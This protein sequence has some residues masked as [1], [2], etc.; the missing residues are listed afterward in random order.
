MISR[1]AW[2][3]ASVPAVCLLLAGCGGVVLEPSGGGRTPA[4]TGRQPTTKAERADPRD[5]TRISQLMVPLLRAANSPRPLD[6]VRV[7]II[8]DDSINAANAG[9]GQFFVTRGLLDKANDEQLQ[10]VLAHEV[11][12]DDL[13]H[14]AK[15]QT[16][17]T[18]LGIGAVILD[19]IFPGTGQIAPIAGSLITRAYSR[20]EELEAD[21]HGVEIL[22][23]VGSSKGAMERTLEWLKGITGSGGRGGFFSTHPGVDERIAA[24]RRMQ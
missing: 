24:L 21:R 22:R 1:R 16:L 4:P 6:Q 17:S 14:V 20:R 8:A 13:G 7:G 12:H 3:R 11:A 15:A 18:G 10:A 2:I 9:S 23:R 19:Q 5:A